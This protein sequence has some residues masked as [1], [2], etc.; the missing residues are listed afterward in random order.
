MSAPGGP[1]GQSIDQIEGSRFAS[2]VNK[3]DLMDLEELA[4]IG[5]KQLFDKQKIVADLDPV[6]QVL[7]QVP[8][9]WRC[10]RKELLEGTICAWLKDADGRYTSIQ[11]ELIP[12]QNV[13]FLF[14]KR[15][16][17]DIY[18]KNKQQN[19]AERRRLLVQRYYMNGPP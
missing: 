15:Y 13:Q 6:Q 10:F 19:Q 3:H 17:D 1:E 9:N 4:I 18:K 12:D 2:A 11:I 14:A 5:W 7:L 16:Y 8:A